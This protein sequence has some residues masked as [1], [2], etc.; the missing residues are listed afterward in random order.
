MAYTTRITENLN[1]QSLKENFFIGNVK[2]DGKYVAVNNLDVAIED[3][4]IEALVVECANELH[5]GNL[6]AAYL[7]WNRN[8]S[9][10][11]TN[12]KKGYNPDAEQDWMRF[13]SLRAYVTKRMAEIKGE[14][15]NGNSKAYWE[16]TMEEIEALTDAK[17]IKSVYDNM[18]SK[19][20]KYPTVVA[21]IAD[22]EDRLAV[23]SKKRNELIAAEKSGIN[24]VDE[25]LL[26][27]L[28]KG[29]KATLSA[30]EAADL[31]AILAKL[32]K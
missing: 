27:K 23:I 10:Q 5:E 12:M 31:F 30:Q 14:A 13:N 18:R 20:S 29:N 15:N 28:S 25:A 26:A 7:A 32:Q 11:Q 19:K 6:Y 3:G 2:V 9:S 16:Y 4:T 22:Y 21:A 24:K 17:T 8:L 1:W